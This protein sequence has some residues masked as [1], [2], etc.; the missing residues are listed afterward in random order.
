MMRKFPSLSFGGILE[1]HKGGNLSFC[2]YTV[3]HKYNIFVIQQYKDKM[4]WNNFLGLDIIIK[5]LP[6]VLI[7]N[8]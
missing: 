2:Y 8:M 3:T 7:L 4:T 1:T 5:D 6:S